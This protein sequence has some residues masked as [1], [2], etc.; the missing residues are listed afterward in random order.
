MPV[1]PRPR[2]TLAWPYSQ[3]AEAGAAAGWPVWPCRWPENPSPS[4]VAQQRRASPGCASYSTR[5]NLLFAATFSC[6]VSGGA[7]YLRQ[8]MAQVG[9][10]THVGDPSRRKRR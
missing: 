9:Q 3:E 6:G 2:P 1:T 8:A 4:T 5:I 10:P 7:R